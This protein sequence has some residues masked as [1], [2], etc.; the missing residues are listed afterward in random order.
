MT[1][2]VFEYLKS[3]RLPVAYQHKL[4]DNEILAEDLDM[5]PLEVVYRFIAT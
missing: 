2:N 1:A 3:K 5:I 4:S